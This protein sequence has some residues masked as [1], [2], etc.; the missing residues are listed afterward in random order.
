M[1]E[2]ITVKRAGGGV[3][4]VVVGSR[5]LAGVGDYL[6]QGRV[7]VITDSNVHRRHM[8]LID[9]YEHIIIGMGESHKTLVTVERLYREFIGMRVDCDCFIL[10][11][12]G[13]VVTDLAGFAASTYMRGLRFGFVSSTLLGQVDASIGGKNG[14]NVD[15]Y[16]NMIG[17]FN[18]PEFVLCDADLLR[19]L[20][21]REF[22]AGLAEVVKAAIVADPELFAM[23]ES[24]TCEEIKG[25]TALLT[26]IVMRAIRVKAAIVGRDERETG[27]R[28][29]LN[30]GHT[31]AH[32][33]ERTT[34]TYIHGEAVAV[35]M[36]MAA[37]IAVRAGVLAGAEE[38]RIRALL[39]KFGLPVRTDIDRN[40]LFKAIRMDK[41][42]EGDTIWFVLPAGIGSCEVRRM[43]FDDVESLLHGQSTLPF[44]SATT[45]TPK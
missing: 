22:R 12:G 24:H 6:P 27:E 35:G 20:P 38:E 18:Q 8:A 31:F 5:L 45:V 14:V 3:S 15:G 23:L 4:T 43:G 34:E 26:D 33:L 19:T 9:T 42:S 2:T 39:E 21:D 13:G 40:R 30:L 32:A 17:T 36:V 7:V 44:R 1:K 16:K 41:K 29:K 10:G 11:F 37:G 28:R 25:D